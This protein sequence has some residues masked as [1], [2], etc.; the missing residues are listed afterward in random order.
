MFS[1][2]TTAAAERCLSALMTKKVSSENLLACFSILVYPAAV[3][4]FSLLKRVL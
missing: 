4:D 2:A 1:E 3:G